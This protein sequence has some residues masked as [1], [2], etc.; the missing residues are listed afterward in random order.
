MFKGMLLAAA[1]CLTRLAGEE[2]YETQHL[3]GPCGFDRYAKPAEM[4]GLEWLMDGDDTIRRIDIKVSD[5]MEAIMTPKFFDDGAW[6]G[7]TTLQE[8]ME[9]VRQKRLRWYHLGCFVSDYA[10]DRQ[11]ILEWGKHIHRVI[12]WRYCGR[13]APLADIDDEYLRSILDPWSQDCSWTRQDTLQ[14]G[15]INAH[16]ELQAASD[17][18]TKLYGRISKMRV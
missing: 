1:R 14:S 5:L 11:L 9:S 12:L 16:R 18:P 8:F 4:V 17:S 3:T 2:K 7:G 15:I 10:P 13:G 6:G